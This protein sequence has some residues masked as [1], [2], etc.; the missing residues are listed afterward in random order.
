MHLSSRFPARR[1]APAV[2]ALIALFGAPQSVFALQQKPLVRIGDQV[3]IVTAELGGDWTRGQVSSL[4]HNALGL[5]HRGTPY[6]IPFEQLEAFQV[7]KRPASLARSAVLYGIAG[8][9]M[10][11]ALVGL[12]HAVCWSS[13]TVPT[14]KVLLG[15]G[16]TAGFVSAAG[17]LAQAGG[18]AHR[19]WYSVH[20][21]DLRIIS[22][23]TGLSLLRLR[24]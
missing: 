20:P 18:N 24:L 17:V 21:E 15:V 5:L 13:C 12:A 14:W 11:G 10:G 9:A 23:G 19:P 3:Q 4:D 22:R 6:T 16:G 8:A 1:V 2:A 7:R